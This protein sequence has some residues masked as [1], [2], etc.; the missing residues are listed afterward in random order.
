M[1]NDGAVHTL[2]ILSQCLRTPVSQKSKKKKIKK[3]FLILCFA[4]R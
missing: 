1:V 2:W 3:Y 4:K